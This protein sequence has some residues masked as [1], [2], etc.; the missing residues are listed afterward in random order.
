MSKFALTR[1][2]S[3][4]AAIASAW[5]IGESSPNEKNIIMKKAAAAT[6]IPKPILRGLEGSLPLRFSQPNKT[7]LTGV[8]ATT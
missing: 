7:T 1:A 6:S 4:P 3:S 8:S 2:G 5:A